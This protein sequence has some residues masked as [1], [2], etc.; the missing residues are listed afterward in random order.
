[1]TRP[2]AITRLRRA[3][4]AAALAASLSAVTFAAATPQD[5]RPAAAAQRP[6]PT[7]MHREWIQH[8]LDSAAARLE[9]KAS[10]ESAWKDYSASVLAL[11]D[12]AGPWRGRPAA[13]ADAATIARER[14]ERAEAFAARLKSIADATARLQGALSADQ[15]AVLTEITRHA[16]REGMMME[17]AM[18]GPGVMEPGMSEHRERM[19]RGMH[20][21]AGPKGPGMMGPGM[22]G[23]GP[24]APPPPTDA[25]K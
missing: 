7:A 9:I 3:T 6:D 11:A 8:R 19:Q 4:A 14:A 18:M 1:M 17:H 10:Q 5:A 25:G 13:D 20:D 2:I 16:G 15:K 23:S 21:G 12:L 24:A 22:M